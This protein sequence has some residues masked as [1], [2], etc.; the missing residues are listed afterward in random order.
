MSFK[1]QIAL[2]FSKRTDEC[3]LFDRPIY[4]Y[5]EKK[6]IKKNYQYNSKRL[7]SWPKFVPQSCLSFRKYFLLNNFN[8]INQKKFPNV[9]MDF[10]L[11]M[12][13][14]IKFEN[15]S[16]INQYLTFYQQKEFGSVSS[17]YKK[18][19]KHWWARRYESHLFLKYL[20]NRLNIK[21]YK[22]LLD[23]YITK[24]IYFFIKYLDK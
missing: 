12:L 2:Y 11:N 18:F 14:F 17:R 23:F 3:F 10:K 20:K 8:L 21:K 9:W 4:Y 19:N 5:N 13:C 22:F 6:I 1:K 15:I 16:M 24:I 7:V